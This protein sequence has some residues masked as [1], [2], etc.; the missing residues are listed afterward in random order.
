MIEYLTIAIK[1]IRSLRMEERNRYKQHYRKLRECYSRCGNNSEELIL[2]E[3]MLDGDTDYE[4]YKEIAVCYLKI[5]QYLE[6]E[7]YLLKYKKI[8][9]KDTSVYR[10]LYEMYFKK[11]DYMAAKDI[12]LCWKE[13]DN[14]YEVND[15]LLKIEREIG[16]DESLK[17]L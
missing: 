13:I 3:E 7:R 9:P 12:L 10:L 8:S 11:E 6:A 15:K 2:L 4:L 5:K 17:E 14:N 1:I 16:T